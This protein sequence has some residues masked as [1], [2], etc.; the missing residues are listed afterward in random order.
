MSGIDSEEKVNLASLSFLWRCLSHSSYC[1]KLFVFFL[2]GVLTQDKYHRISFSLG[3]KCETEVDLKR[4][5]HFVVSPDGKKTSKYNAFAL[6]RAAAWNALDQRNAALVRGDASRGLTLD[7][8]DVAALSII[9]CSPAWL[10]E[11]SRLARS[12]ASSPFTVPSPSNYSVS[13]LSFQHR[14][15]AQL[16]TV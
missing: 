9:V 6:R 1:K 2:L 15:D 5:T 10:D 8:A 7:V 13:Y 4:L 16:E 14:F 3:A 11:C 12:S